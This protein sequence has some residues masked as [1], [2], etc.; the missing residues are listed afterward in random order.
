MS[1]VGQAKEDKDEIFSNGQWEILSKA[2]FKKTLGKSANKRKYEQNKNMKTVNKGKWSKVK[3]LS[4]IKKRQI[5]KFKQ[6]LK[7]TKK[8]KQIKL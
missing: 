6:N 8:I 7:I 4:K 5:R 3:I 1:K 2:K